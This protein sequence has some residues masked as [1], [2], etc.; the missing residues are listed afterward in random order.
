[1]DDIKQCLIDAGF[2]PIE[3][4]TYLSI[5]AD[6]PVS[7]GKVAKTTGNYRANTYQ[8]IERLKAK[9]FVSETQGKSS[10]MFIASSPDHILEESKLKQKAL[11][12][13]VAQMKL[14]RST[15]IMTTQM[16][17]I[18]GVNGWRNLL[19]EFL[20]IG[21]ERVVYGVP[22][23]AVELMGDFFDQYHKKRAKQKL[24]LWHLFNHDAKAR[25]ETTNRLPYTKSRY[26]PKELDQPVSTSVCGSLVA[27]TVYQGK[28]VQT[29]VIDN[30]AI[31]DAYRQY[32]EFLWKNAKC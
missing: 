15:S 27:L 4:S 11:E 17:M 5:L 24:K 6:G 32:F 14:M 23:N 26:L 25:I 19:N 8:A 12:N 29:I 30:A 1:M 28:T 20:V 21:K 18:E 22:N 3:V 31:A 7:A 9:G 10:K 13:A 16:R 2:T